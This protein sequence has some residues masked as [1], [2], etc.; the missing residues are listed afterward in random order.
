MTDEYDRVRQERSDPSY[1]AALPRYMTLVDPAF[2]RAKER[3]EFFFIWTLLGI[4]GLQDPGWNPYQTSIE[5]VDEMCTLQA[6]AETLEA[7]LHLSLLALWPCAHRP[8]TLRSRSQSGI[9]GASGSFTL[10]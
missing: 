8:A 3:S 2:T 7:Q 4:R 6:K 1:L 9:N 10:L 5:V